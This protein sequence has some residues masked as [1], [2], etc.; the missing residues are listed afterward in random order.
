AEDKIIS[1]L[2]EHKLL[3]ETSL[4]KSRDDSKLIAH[5]KKMIAFLIDHKAEIDELIKDRIGYQGKHT[6]P[7]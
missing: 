6:P 7:K 2:N 5:S 4:I 1:Y 3:L